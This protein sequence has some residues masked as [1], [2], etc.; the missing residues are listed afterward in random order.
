[1]ILNGRLRE[2]EVRLPNTLARSNGNC[3]PPNNEMTLEL[4]RLCEDP[5]LERVVVKSYDRDQL[6]RLHQR[7]YDIGEIWLTDISWQLDRPKLQDGTGTWPWT[8]LA[9]QRWDK[10]REERRKA[11]HGN[12]SFPNLANSARI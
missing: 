7:L 12:C 11:I 5:Y 4:K 2:L 1:M 9:A 8:S 6:R 3:Y 10:E